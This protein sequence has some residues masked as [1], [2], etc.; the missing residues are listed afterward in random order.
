[1]PETTSQIY[2]RFVFKSSFNHSKCWPAEYAIWE[3]FNCLG[4]PKQIHDILDKE[5]QTIPNPPG[6]GVYRPQKVITR[7][8]IFHCD[9][10]LSF[11]IF[12]N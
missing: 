12:K 10:V 9:T 11:Q 8:A 2:T 1:M 5:F 6:S 4:G 3:I 7:G